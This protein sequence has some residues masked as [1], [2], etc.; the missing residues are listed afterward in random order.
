MVYIAQPGSEKSCG[1]I[2]LPH[3]YV[4]TAAHCAHHLSEGSLVYT[5][6]PSTEPC[7]KSATKY[8]I[9]PTKP[10]GSDLLGINVPDL[11]IAKLATPLCGVQPIDP[12]K[13]IGVFEKG[14]TYQV[15]G[16]GIGTDDD[17][18][19]P[20]RFTATFEG[21][22][23]YLLDKYYSKL[24]G[25]NRTCY[26]FNARVFSELGDSESY[27]R[28]TGK[29]QSV[30]EGDS[31]SPVYRNVNGSLVLYG[32]NSIYV[33]NASTGQSDCDEAFLVGVVNVAPYRDWI[34]SVSAK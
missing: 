29:D 30:D 19:Y 32:I 26:D 34:A 13:Q 11:A 12:Q 9:F 8:L 2:L 18:L 21:A 7:A 33:L 28:P 27:L 15:P 5:P 3:D 22:P 16:Y 23:Q 10:G 14:A 24:K 20:D 31:G 25:A 1:G 17:A 6:G 4:L